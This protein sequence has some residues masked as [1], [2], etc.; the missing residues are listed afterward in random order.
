MGS[1]PKYTFFQRRHTDQSQIY[2]EFSPHSDQNDYHQKVYKQ[3][4]GEG[5]DKKNSPILLVGMQI[6]A[7]TRHHGMEVP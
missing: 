4:A 3:H 1:R 2:N 5:V 7:I 6:V